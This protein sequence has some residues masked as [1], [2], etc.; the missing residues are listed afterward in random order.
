MLT[1]LKITFLVLL[2]AAC[3]TVPKQAVPPPPAT[4]TRPVSEVMHGV[5]ITDPYRWLEDQNAP[6]TRAWIDK[7]NAYTDS[8]LANR[9][10][11]ALFAKRLEELQRTDTIEVPEY[12][13]GR[14]F[15][16]K[17]AAGQDL[18]AIYMREGSGADQ[19]LIDP[20]SM[21][22]KH[23]TNADIYDVSDDGKTLAYWIRQGGADEVEVHF[24]D[25]DARRETGAPI[26]PVSRFFNASLSPD[27][28]TV[29]YTRVVPEGP[30]VFRRAVAGG[31]PELLFG[32]GY[33]RDK[34]IYS[35][36]SADGTHLGVQVLHGSAATDVEIYAKDLRTDAP[37]VTVAK[38]LGARSDAAFA[39]NTL[40][41]MT[42]WKAPNYRVMTATLDDAKNWKDLVTENPNA[43][44]QD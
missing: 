6:E 30:R 1:R 8:I 19:L 39:D 13:N 27:G 15:F 2:A 7:Q 4:E 22:P 35:F 21:N 5:T 31:E 41:I 36:L 20:A 40:V 10:E 26:L 33:A 3:A 11:K 29:Y 18:L 25:V 38:H 9:P 43:A 17:R 28:K 14:Y 44:I 34:I 37:F 12:R 16:R 32:E 23:T 24:F 42:N